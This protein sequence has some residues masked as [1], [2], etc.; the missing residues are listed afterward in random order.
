MQNCVLTIHDELTVA[1]GTVV[2]LLTV[3]TGTVVGNFRTEE[4]LSVVA[5]RSAGNKYAD[6][7]SQEDLQHKLYYINI[8]IYI[9]T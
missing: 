3:A 5:A 6:H 4:S 7:N 8:T 9:G 2:K 1:T